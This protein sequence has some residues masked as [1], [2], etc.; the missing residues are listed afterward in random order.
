MVAAYLITGLTG[1]MIGAFAG[2]L[3]YATFGG[4]LCGYLA[5]GIGAIQAMVILRI[6]TAIKHD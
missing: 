6:A 1:G 2:Y 3:I 4:G 5:G